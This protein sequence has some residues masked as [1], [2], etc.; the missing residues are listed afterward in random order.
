MDIM[1]RAINAFCYCSV[2]FGIGTLL[3]SFILI[4]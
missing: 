3:I 4:H 2:L 1:K